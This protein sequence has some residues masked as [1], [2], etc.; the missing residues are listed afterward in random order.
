MHEG[1]LSRPQTGNIFSLHNSV[2]IR[3]FQYTVDLPV[4]EYILLGSLLGTL[5]RS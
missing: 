4:H 3:T 1:R 5:V 2:M